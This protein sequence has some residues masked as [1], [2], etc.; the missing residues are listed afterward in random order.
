MCNN[1]KQGKIT[2]PVKYLTGILENIKNKPSGNAA[3]NSK[4]LGSN[5]FEPREYD[6]DDLERKLL[7]W[8]R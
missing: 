5:N 8:D 4:K 6:Y 7:G 3:D 2:A 1:S